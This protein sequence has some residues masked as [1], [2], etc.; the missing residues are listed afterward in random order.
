[1]C[2]GIIENT[3]FGLTSNGKAGRIRKNNKLY[4]QSHANETISCIHA[5]EY[6]AYKLT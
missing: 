5:S 4:L 1:M 6:N 2:G 3:D